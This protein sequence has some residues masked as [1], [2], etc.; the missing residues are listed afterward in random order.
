MT[1]EARAVRGA[2]YATFAREGHAPSVG[3]LARTLALEPRE[4]DAAL[5]RRV[6]RAAPNSATRRR[7][8]TVFPVHRAMR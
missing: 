2:I 5:P 8:P 6:R 3:E 7:R 4:V 1:G